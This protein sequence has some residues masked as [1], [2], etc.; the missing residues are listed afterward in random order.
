MSKNRVSQIIK[1][2]AASA[3]MLVYCLGL[4]SSTL[5]SNSKPIACKA[6]VGRITI[7]VDPR[8]ELISIVFRL[9]GNPEYNGSALRP[10]VKAIERHFKVE[11]FVLLASLEGKA[12]TATEVLELAGEKAAVLSR[13]LTRLNAEC[14]DPIIDTVFDI[15]LRANRLPPIPQILLDMPEAGN[16]DVDYMGPL[17]QAQKKH[18]QVQS[19][20]Q[21]IAVAAPIIEIQPSVVDNVDWDGTFIDLLQVTGF[22]QKRINTSDKVE[23][24]RQGR[25]NVEAQEAAKEELAQAAEVTN[26]LFYL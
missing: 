2:F 8:V 6:N 1:A 10:Y 19:I 26:F 4:P 16:I 13:P 20:E 21:S 25:A 9:A 12:K 14:L 11:F 5:A 18:F 7:E 23:K 17:A 22:S 3:V 15:E 24:I